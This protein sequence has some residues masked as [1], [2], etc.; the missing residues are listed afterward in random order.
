MA[1]YRTGGPGS[2]FG[3]TGGTATEGNDGR[4]PT[5]DENDAL[6][7]TNGAPSTT[8]K[9]VTNTDSRN[10]NERTPVDDSATNAK[11]ANMPANTV[12]GNN[13]GVA[14]NPLDLTR[15]QITVM[16]DA[17][18]EL[19]QGAV[20]L[21]TQ[22]EVNAGT[23]AVRAVTPATL[24]SKIQS[25]SATVNG[26]G[27]W[28]TVTFPVAFPVGTAPRI[29]ANDASGGANRFVVSIRNQSNTSFQFLPA[30]NS[31][32]NGSVR[33]GIHTGADP[34]DWVAIANA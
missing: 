4:V 19:L 22:V 32:N 9:Y 1:E 14:A 31:N 23:D 2:D 6:V 18:T 26:S 15:T 12:K 28:Q 24:D 5:Q 17:A 16:L 11:L 34:V 20:E 25:G 30:N 21:A 27:T 33:T 3:T 7:G 13:T 29:V 8:N 10:T